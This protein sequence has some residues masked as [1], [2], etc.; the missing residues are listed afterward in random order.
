MGNKRTVTT[1][2]SVCEHSCGMQV[3]AQ[4]NEIVEIRGLKEHPYS[5]GFL[6]PKGLAAKDIWAAPDRLKNPLKRDGDNWK[7]ISLKSSLCRIMHA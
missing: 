4:D 6:C 2:C 5:K 7:P 3:T 1:Y